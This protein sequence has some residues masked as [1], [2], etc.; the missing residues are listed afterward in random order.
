MSSVVEIK[1][2]TKEE[3]IQRALKICEAKIEQVVKVEEKIKSKSF[4]G[5]FKKEGLFEIEI[6]KEKEAESEVVKK[7]QEILDYMGLNLHMEILK[8][9]D[10]FVLLNLYGEDNGIII[11]KKG[12]TLNSFE[13]L[14][15]SLVKNMKVEVDVEGFK[16]K[17]ANTLRDLARKMSEKAL[18]SDKAI[19]LNP[20]PPRERKIIHEIVN[21]YEDLDTYSEG[22][23]PKRYIVIKKKR[24]G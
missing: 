13:Y 7:A 18:K 8:S 11:G 15:N 19:R 6:K 24:Q 1:A 5:F 23:D 20:M 14:L 9:S 16:E 4:L 17:R 12:K 3:A 22:R 2:M 21:K 10:H